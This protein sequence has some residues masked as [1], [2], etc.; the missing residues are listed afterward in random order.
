MAI[1]YS[2]LETSYK[3][4]DKRKI[5][6]VID[7]IIADHGKTRGDI[8]VVLCSDEVIL[9]T[10]RQ[11]LEHDYY[12]DII[13]FDYCVGGEVSGDLMISVDTVANN[14]KGLNISPLDEMRRIIFHGVLHLVGY[15][16]KEPEHKTIMTQMEDK[17]LSYFASL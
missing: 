1:T 14:A 3:L 9:S 16:D 12:T 15:K 5:N 17:Y 4:K 8:A 10:N 13:T 7:A 2:T 6:K 11:Y